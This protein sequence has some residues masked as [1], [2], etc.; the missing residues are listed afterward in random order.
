FRICAIEPT[1]MM[2]SFIE[3]A[4][5]EIR[6]RVNSGR[7]ICA[8][9][10]GVDSVTTAILVHKAIGNQLHC[11]F[12]DHGLLRD[13]EA[14]QVK[15]VF[16]KHFKIPLEAINASDRF[17][18][19]LEGVTE[20][21]QKRI[22]VGNEFIHV[23]EE[24]A[25]KIKDAKY[26]AQGTL[27]PDVI[28]SQAGS[29]GPADRIKT[30]HNVGGLPDY[31]KLKLVEPMRYL[32]KDEVRE[33]AREL[34]IAR[35]IWARQPFPGPGLAIR[36]IGEVT[37]DRL[38][39]LRQA[40]K[41]ILEEVHK[42]GLSDKIWQFFAVLPVVKSV[43]VMGDR[44]TYAYP[45]IFRAVT[46]RDG[47]TADWPR[48]PYKILEKMS[49]RVLNEVPGVNRFLYDVSTKPPATIEWE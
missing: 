48:I 34:G 40:D 6:D 11:I 17:L 10:G 46:S 42:A 22:I 31:M 19:R 43:G 23:F 14:D 47:M 1:W 28:E 45:I 3:H 36:I 35:E 27:Y 25:K 7:V 30:H 32:F 20:P 24:E 12:V 33:M 2:V 41:I 9:S 29:A 21:E 26:L 38:A 37:P 44:R 8:V 49:R 15:N 39:I 16:L 13:G 4:T 18:Q 5:E